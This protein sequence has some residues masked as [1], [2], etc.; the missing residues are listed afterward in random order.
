MKY[1]EVGPKKGFTANSA[2]VQNYEK[3]KADG[4]KGWCIHH[5]LETHDEK[6]VFR[7]KP[8]TSKE[9]KEKGLYYNRPASELIWLRKKDHQILHL[10]ARGYRSPG[11][12][13]YEDRLNFFEEYYGD[14]DWG[15]D[16]IEECEQKL[17]EIRDHELYLKTL[18]DPDQLQEHLD[19]STNDLNI[20]RM[21]LEDLKEQGIKCTPIEHLYKREFK[22]NK[23]LSELIETT[24]KGE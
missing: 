18:G 14:F 15:D 11:A 22:R 16:E 6:G 3:A 21:V 19:K 17:D 10:I 13:E 20:I 23:R 5:R 12:K 1:E 24:S 8:V 4:F 9:L 2:L 7:D